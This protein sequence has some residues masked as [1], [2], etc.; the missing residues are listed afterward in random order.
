MVELYAHQKKLLDNENNDNK[1]L[2]WETGTGKT[3]ASKLWLQQKNRLR[4]ALVICPKQ[5]RE[6]WKEDV[7]QAHVYS[8]EDF[9][10]YDLPDNPSAIVI[11]EMDYLASPLYIAKSRSQRTE[12]AYHYILSNPQAHIL[13]LTA[14]PVRSSPANMHTLA[15]LSRQYPPD[16]K[17]WYLYRD[18]YYELQY[19]PYLPRPAWL[20]TA[21]WRTDMQELIDRYTITACMSDVVELPP[22]THEVIKL[23]APDY[24]SN[25]E[26]EPKKQFVYDHKL[27][28]ESKPKKILQLS[29]GYRK[30]VVVAYYREQIEQLYT[31]LSKDRK[32]FVVHGGVHNQEE[33]INE[34]ERDP[35]CF[36]VI[37]ASISAGFEL[38]SFDTMI[39][40]SQSYSVRDYVQMK[41]RI[42]RIDALK[43]VRYIYL[44]G[45]RCDK[46]V[47]DNV[48]AG[49]DFIPSEYLQHGA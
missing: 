44:H 26:W 18:K 48:M 42:R 30:V 20:P 12:K 43:K 4:C 3:Y 33:V 19:K 6:K 40:T 35:E 16:K 45:G 15:V 22:E 24:D 34:A 28:Q 11:D 13:G 7:P 14:T 47:Y 37:Q 10:K 49:K 39:F 38:K 9:K 21:T 5:I 8:F 41:G 17:H 27:E 29:R 31:A 46:A 1:I 32:T 25:P 2:S 36:I 23:K